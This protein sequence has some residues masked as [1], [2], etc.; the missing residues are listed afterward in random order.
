MTGTDPSRS[1]LRELD[2]LGARIAADARDTEAIETYWARMFRLESWALLLAS[3]NRNPLVLSPNVGPTLLAFTSAAQAIATARR[4]QRPDPVPIL[5]MTPTQVTDLAE[6]M[7]GGGVRHVA[8]D[9]DGHT[10]WMGA[11]M[12]RQLARDVAAVELIDADNLD[13]AYREQ[14]TGI[15]RPADGQPAAHWVQ[16]HSDGEQVRF[17]GHVWRG[18]EPNRQEVF[19]TAIGGYGQRLDDAPGEELHEI[20]QTW[21]AR[22]RRQL[23]AMPP[24]AVNEW[25]VDDGRAAAWIHQHM[26]NAGLPVH[27]LYTPSLRAAPQPG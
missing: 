24:G 20:T 14:I 11:T 19:L 5:R 16:T 21:V 17:H 6:R 23:E 9:L 25:H 15:I 10:V 18:T 8:I 13:P 7:S 1:E 26:E 12:L 2:A 22:A 3:D 4:Q 27:V